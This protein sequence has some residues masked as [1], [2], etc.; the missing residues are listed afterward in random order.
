[1]NK[2]IASDKFVK[3][4]IECVKEY[5]KQLMETRDDGDAAH[6]FNSSL[7]KFLIDNKKEIILLSSLNFERPFTTWL[8][9]YLYKG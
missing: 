4:L 2:E 8:K 5:K 1:M 9:M 7:K 3:K 6:F